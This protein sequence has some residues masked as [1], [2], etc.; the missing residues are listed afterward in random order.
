MV[1]IGGNP[2]STEDFNPLWIS[3]FKRTNAYAVWEKIT[4][5]L[6]F[7]IIEP[8]WVQHRLWSSK[9]SI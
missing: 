3:E 6:L 9:A 7:D 8:R 2:N 1:V 4:D 5:P